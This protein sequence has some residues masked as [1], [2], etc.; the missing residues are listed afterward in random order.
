M[1]NI[2]A[3]LLLTVSLTANAGSSLVVHLTGHHINSGY[4]YNEE[5]YGLGYR[6]NTGTEVGFFR[7]SYYGTDNDKANGAGYS[8]YAKQLIWHTYIGN[9]EFALDVGAAMYGGDGN[10][11]VIPLV[12]PMVKFDIG[13]NNKI[14]FSYLPVIANTYSERD[15]TTDYYDSEGNII[16]TITETEKYNESIMYGV[17]TISFSH[18]FK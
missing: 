5:N 7:N 9:T 3:I 4:D 11:P 17:I 12:Q 13:H 15:I 16:E 14:I 8:L 18:Y 2:Y 6:I 1:K 10:L